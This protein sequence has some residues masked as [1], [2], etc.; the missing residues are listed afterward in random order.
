MTLAL[1]IMLTPN[2]QK[3]PP[4]SGLHWADVV[5]LSRVLTNTN[6]K[7]SNFYVSPSFS[8]FR[9]GIKELFPLVIGN[10]DYSTIWV[11]GADATRALLKE[12]R[13]AGSTCIIHCAPAEMLAAFGLRR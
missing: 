3:V 6:A 13:R 4:S 11:Q 12:S 1:A 7:N 5:T 8:D 2:G 10:P 9:H